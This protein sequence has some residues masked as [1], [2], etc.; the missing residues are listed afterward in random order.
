MEDDGLYDKL[1]L[2]RRVLMAHMRSIGDAFAEDLLG[3]WMALAA[4]GADGQA[5]PQLRHG[6][7]AIVDHFTNLVLGN[8]VAD[9]DD[10]R[11]TLL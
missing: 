11:Y 3:M 9:T 2:C 8:V 6:N 5:I 1:S 7:D 4:A 10:H